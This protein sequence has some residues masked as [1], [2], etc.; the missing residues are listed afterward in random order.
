MKYL[1]LTLSLLIGSLNPSFAGV[2]YVTSSELSP[3]V[4]KTIKKKQKRVKR[5]LFKQKR[6]P[7]KVRSKGRV[8][9]LMIAG[10]G[11]AILSLIFLAITIFF[12]ISTGLVFDVL[13]ALTVFFA[14]LTIISFIMASVYSKNVGVRGEQ[15]GQNGGKATY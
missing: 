8:T 9:L 11:C 5:K 3:P 7:N 6:K 2:S 4:E 14:V 13:I 12:F 10:V 1:I 15:G